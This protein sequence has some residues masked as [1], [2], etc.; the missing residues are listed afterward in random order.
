[1]LILR[2][3]R[4][5]GMRIA[6]AAF[7]GCVQWPVWAVLELPGHNATVD[8]VQPPMSTL[9]PRW[10]LRFHAARPRSMKIAARV[11]FRTLYRSGKTG[12]SYVAQRGSAK[13]FTDRG[14]HCQKK[15]A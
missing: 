12:H 9:S 1:M 7:G 8:A 2:V 13:K 11:W 15:S 14:R 5:A 10:S 3:Q 4:M 6:T